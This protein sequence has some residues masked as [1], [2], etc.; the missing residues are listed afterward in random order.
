MCG[1]SGVLSP[2]NQEVG[3]S[4]G[5][6]VAAMVSVLGHRGPDTSG[7]WTNPSG[8]IALG[9]TRLAIVDLSE[10][11]SQPRTSA[12]G[13]WTITYNGE[14]YNSEYLRQS[15]GSVRWRGHSDTETLVAGF[16]AWGIE[17]TIKRAVGMFAF[18]VWGNGWHIITQNGIILSFNNPF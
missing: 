1:V 6:L 4:Q 14:L 9:H 5:D 18:A 10:T 3:Q 15:V 8:R 2:S 17:G 13:R 7:I 12:D 11:G 16:D